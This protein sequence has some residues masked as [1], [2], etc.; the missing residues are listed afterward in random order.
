M[1]PPSATAAP[2]FGAPPGES[3]PQ[4]PKI[5]VNVAAR[6]RE[7][8]TIRIFAIVFMMMCGMLSILDSL[9]TLGGFST[10]A[11]VGIGL[12]GGAIVM[13]FLAILNQG[14][15]TVNNITSILSVTLMISGAAA[16]PAILFI[17]K[18]NLTEVDFILSLMFAITFLLFIEYM[19]AVRRFWEIGEMAIVKNLRE[20]DFGHV[21]RQYMLMSFVWLVII[22][23]MTMGVVGLQYILQSQ[24]PAQVGQS[25]EINSVYGLAIAEGVVFVL[26]AVILSLILGR[27]EYAQSFRTSMATARPAPKKPEGPITAMIY[28]IKSGQPAQTGLSATAPP[29][30]AR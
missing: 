24:L 18:L 26:I 7:I 21:L 5:A 20:F 27:K 15:R 2:S 22:I 6:Y 29:P 1:A 9:M 13:G 8:G 4:A 23:I 12:T 14:N 10:L 28:D 30:R 25:A 16:R 17:G 3:A 19:S 11:G